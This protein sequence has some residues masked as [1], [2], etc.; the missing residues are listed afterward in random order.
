MGSTDRRDGSPRRSPR[1]QHGHQAGP[2]QPTGPPQPQIPTSA[3][4]LGTGL[5]NTDTNNETCRAVRAPD[6]GP[7][8]LRGCFLPV[9]STGSK[10]NS[11]GRNR[12]G[13]APSSSCPPAPANPPVDAQEGPPEGLSAGSGHVKQRDSASGA[14][15]PTQLPFLS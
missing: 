13:P 1:S 11:R 9:P 5:G 3:R 2:A 7:E 4:S 15:L 8:Q 14:A 6:K 10:H 12:T